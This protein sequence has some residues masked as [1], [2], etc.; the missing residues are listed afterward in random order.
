VLGAESRTRPPAR[1]CWH[2][3][4]AIAA[5]LGQLVVIAVAMLVMTAGLKTNG[6]VFT[7]VMTKTRRLTWEI[8]SIVALVTAGGF[9]AYLIARAMATR[10]GVL[11]ILVQVILVCVVASLAAWFHRAIPVPPGTHTTGIPGP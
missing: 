3:A 9:L 6:M 8:G 7:E 5:G 2:R 10:R 11:A 1:G 4:L